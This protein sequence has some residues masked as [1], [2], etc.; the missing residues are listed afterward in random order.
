MDSVLRA[1]TIYLIL[2]VVFRLSGKRAL[3]DVTT[4]DFILLLIISEATQNALLGNDFSITNAAIVIL[5]LVTVDIALSLVTARSGRV[6]KLLSDVPTIVVEDGK[7]IVDRMARLRVSVDDVLE[8]GR[9]TQGIERLEQ[10]KYAVVERSGAISV[11][12]M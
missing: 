11:I 5:T 12:P 4:F 2:M 8:R 1:L 6:E 3:A 7:P 9:T 10:I